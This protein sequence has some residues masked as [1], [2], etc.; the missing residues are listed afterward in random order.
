[1]FSGKEVGEKCRRDGDEGGLADADDHVAQQQFVVGV[2]DGAQQ[3]GGAPDERA[4][5]HDPFARIAIGQ[6]RDQRSGH[7]VADEKGGGQEADLRVVEVKLFLHQGLH[8]EQHVAVDVV[9]KVQRRK[10]QQRASGVVFGRHGCAEDI[11][12]PARRLCAACKNTSASVQDRNM[13]S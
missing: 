2:G 1:M 3:R 8:G 9:Q 4:G 12:A 5:G 11:T 7:H 6:R 13:L 10:Q